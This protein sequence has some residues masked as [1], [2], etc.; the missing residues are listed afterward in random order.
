MVASKLISTD[1]T[2]M[3]S[4]SGHSTRDGSLSK[5]YTSCGKALKPKSHSMDGHDR[6]QVVGDGEAQEQAQ[7]V[8]AY[9]SRVPAR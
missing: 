2:E 3:A 1:V 6:I 8:P 7:A 4:T 5:R 9:R